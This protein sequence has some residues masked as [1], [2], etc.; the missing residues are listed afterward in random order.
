VTI[1]YMFSVGLLYTPVPC[2]PY[3]NELSR[4]AAASVLLH[5][6]WK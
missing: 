1:I 2:L 3:C 5:L 6:D 4:A